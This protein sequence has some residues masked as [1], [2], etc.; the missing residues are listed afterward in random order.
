VSFAK[1]NERAA[2]VWRQARDALTKDVLPPLS[3]SPAST[4]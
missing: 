2:R 3:I 1:M 4:P